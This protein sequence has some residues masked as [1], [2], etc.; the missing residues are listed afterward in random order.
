MTEYVYSY[1]RETFNDANPEEAIKSLFIRMS[2]TWF[3][4]VKVGD[5]YKVYRGVKVA[6]LASGF[7]SNH[8]VEHILD[9]MRETAYDDAGEWADDFG[10]DVTEE[11]KTE[12]Q[13][14][15]EQ[16]ADKYMDVNFYGVTDI[17]EIEV[18]V[19]KEML[20]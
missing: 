12:L 7:V 13:S 4:D 18:E 16:W 20:E 5:K 15:I 10:M 19:T 17:E 2:A 1:D 8:T 11:A 6:R 14:F 9:D 3:E